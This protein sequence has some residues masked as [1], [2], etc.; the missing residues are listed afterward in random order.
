MPST[1]IARKSCRPGGRTS[2]KAKRKSVVAVSGRRW[3]GDRETYAVISRRVGGKLPTRH[4]WEREKKKENFG[5]FMLP[6][7]RIEIG[8]KRGG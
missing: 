7:L 6:T 5:G 1:D 3:Q 2:L 4:N 8:G